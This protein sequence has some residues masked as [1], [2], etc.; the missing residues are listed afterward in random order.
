MGTSDAFPAKEQTRVLRENGFAGTPVNQSVIG[1]GN[2][3][4]VPTSKTIPA[5]VSPAIPA[6]KVTI[7]RG[8]TQYAKQTMVVQAKTGPTPRGTPR[9]SKADA[10]VQGP[11]NKPPPPPRPHGY[12]PAPPKRRKI[13]FNH[14]LEIAEISNDIFQR[15]LEYGGIMFSIVG[16]NGT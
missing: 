7:S 2:Q 5:V 4:V 6:Q 10:P 15:K 13:S 8:T 12:K 9:P 11:K 1:N 14:L 3:S 16:L